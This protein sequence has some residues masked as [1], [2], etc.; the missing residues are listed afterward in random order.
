MA[1]VAGRA[2]AVEQRL[3]TVRPLPLGGTGQEKRVRQMLMDRLSADGG[4]EWPMLD[5]TVAQ[6]RDDPS[7]EWPASADAGGARAHSS[8]AGAKK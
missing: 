2:R 4:R 1:V 7:T 3:Q 5:S 8:A 6:Q